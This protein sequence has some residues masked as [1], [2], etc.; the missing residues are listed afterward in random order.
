MARSPRIRHLRRANI[1]RM[2]RSK[3]LNDF[4]NE[5]VTTM[6][7]SATLSPFTVVV[8]DADNALNL[9]AHGHSVGEGPFLLSNAGGALPAGLLAGVNYYVKAVV[10]AGKF[11]VSR[12]RGGAVVVPTDNGTGVHSIKRA[13]TKADVFAVLKERGSERVAKLTDI[14]NL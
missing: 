8:L 1:A 10:S 2:D 6:T 14:D 11:T 5:R 4:I 9:A 13:T 7:A 12:T 3:R